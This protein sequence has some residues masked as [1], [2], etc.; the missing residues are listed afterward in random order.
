[1][2]RVQTSCQCLF[3]V[4]N[5]R[6]DRDITHK[7][8]QICLSMVSVVNTIE[9]LPALHLRLVRTPRCLKSAGFHSGTFL[10]E[11]KSAPLLD[12]TGIS[13][14][15][16]CHWYNPCEYIYH[17]YEIQFVINKYKVTNTRCIFLI[18]LRL[19][20]QAWLNLSRNVK[21]LYL[22]FFPSSGVRRVQAFV[23]KTFVQKK[24]KIPV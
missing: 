6:N 10:K 11:E 13:P 7:P 9:S 21:D 17:V 8:R 3:H 14:R 22:I 1:M 18:Q 4:D 16:K 5:P 19:L 12:Q 23:K 24:K 20:E 2:I 15:V